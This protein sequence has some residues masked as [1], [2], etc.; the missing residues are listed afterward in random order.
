MSLN[1]GD[2][3]A[4]ATLASAKCAA[5]GQHEVKDY[6]AQYEEFVQA[7]EELNKSKRRPARQVRI[8]GG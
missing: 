2:K 5:S 8:T 3:L 4:A 7:F 6:M 1:D